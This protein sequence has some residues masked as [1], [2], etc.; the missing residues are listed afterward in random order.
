MQ[1]NWRI[2]FSRLRQYPFYSK[3]APPAEIAAHIDDS[4]FEKS[5]NY[6]RDKARYAFVSGL[7]RQALD[8]VLLHYGVY[9]WAWISAGDIIRKLGY[10][11]D[12]EV[13][14]TLYLPWQLILYLLR[15]QIL[16]SNVFAG[17]LFLQSVIVSVPFSVY[18][19]FVLEEKHGFNKTSPRLFVSDLY[20]GWLL[21]IGIG[22]PF[23]SAFLYVF[24]WAGDRFL[25]WLMGFL[26]AGI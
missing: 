9:A 6:G 25:P 23:L 11:P 4:T 13:R 10:G 5:Q 3:K 22:A 24:K 8:S 19:T 21:A 15:I 1:Y 20:K 7:L 26:W 16:Q 17:I 12:Y 14:P 2:A 18:Q